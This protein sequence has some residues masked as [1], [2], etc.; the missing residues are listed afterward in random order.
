MRSFTEDRTITS[1]DFISQYSI[2][3]SD[4]PFPPLKLSESQLNPAIVQ[5]FSSN[6]TE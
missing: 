3:G 4:D 6:Q 5:W 1:A 2:N